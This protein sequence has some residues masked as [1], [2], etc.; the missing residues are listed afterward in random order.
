MG[1]F[2]ERN[3]NYKGYMHKKCLVCGNEL[4]SGARKTSKYCS[5]VCHAAAC[6]KYPVE[7]KQCPT[8]GKDFTHKGAY[9]S[10]ECRILRDYS[11]LSE[12][13]KKKRRIRLAK[14][15]GEPVRIG[16]PKV[17]R[18]PRLCEVCG[19]GMLL[20]PCE[21]KKGTKYCSREC[22]GKGVSLRQTGENHHMY[23][24]GMSTAR[25][26]ARQLVRRSPFYFEWRKAVFSRDAHTCRSCLKVGGVLHAHH[27]VPWVEDP[28]KRLKVSNGVTLCSECHRLWHLYDRRGYFDKKESLLQEKIIVALREYGF[29]VYNVPGTPMGANGISDLIV[30]YRGMFGAIEV[31]VFPNYLS[32]LQRRFANNVKGAG[33]IFYVAQSEDDVGRIIEMFETKLA[34]G[35]WLV[36][37]TVESEAFATNEHE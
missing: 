7:L 16:A 6:R 19:K 36:D 37:D 28:K 35:S 27:V 20:R 23:K 24:D 29:L 4:G 8:C 34:Y 1:D 10:T 3:P 5:R 13:A 25:N 18:V 14:L 32:E 22:Y 31:K 33:G 30:C 21:I 17:A 26:S 15:N 9:C 2:G 12:S 11:T